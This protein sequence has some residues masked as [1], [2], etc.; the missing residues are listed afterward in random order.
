MH[1]KH[2]HSS[3][4][5]IL[6][7][8]NDLS[9]DQRVHK[10]ATSLVKFGFKPFLVGFGTANAPLKESR[11]YGSKLLPRFFSKGPLFYA[12]FNIKLFFFLLFSRTAVMV[13]NDLDSLLANYLAYRIKRIFTKKIYLVYDSHELFTELPE[14]NGRK[15]TRGI[16]LAI[17]KMIV[18]KLKNAYTVCQ[19]IADYYQTKYKIR[20]QVIRNMPLIT[21][22]LEQNKMPRLTLP[23]NKKI[24]LYQGALNIGRGIEQMIEIMPSIDKAVFIIAGSGTIDNDLRKMVIEEKLSDK[25]IFTG[26]LPFEQL[27]RLTEQADIGLVLQ[28]DISLSYRYVLPNRL[29]DFIKAGIPVIAS[30]LPEIKKIIDL[31]QIGL[32]INGFDKDSLLNKTNRLLDDEALICNIKENMNRCKSRYCWESEEAKLMQVY[33]NLE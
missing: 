10:V 33:Q 27:N 31:E 32:T 6:S 26:K 25:V 7:V 19:P 15:I 13:A 17:E 16:W 5:I 29:F 21:Q 11:A 14:L 30:E 3:K 12:E 18:P 4:T 22:S 28:E 24:I 8:T 2:P 23:T 9:A 1:D 20:M